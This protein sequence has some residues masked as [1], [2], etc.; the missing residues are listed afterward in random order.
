MIHPPGARRR[1]ILAANI[2]VA[3]LVCGLDADFQP[4]RLNRYLVQARQSGARPVV[5]LNK[6]DLCPEVPRMPADVPA[7]AISTLQGDLASLAARGKP[8][9]CSAPPG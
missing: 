9:R 3:F 4:N 8:P 6:A 1:R 5:V 2:D 7:T